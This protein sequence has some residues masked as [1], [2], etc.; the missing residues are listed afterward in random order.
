MHSVI[1]KFPSDTFYGGR[2]RDAGKIAKRKFDGDDL[3]KLDSIFQRVVFLDLVHS[4]EDQ[5]QEGKIFKNNAM[6]VKCTFY[7][8]RYFA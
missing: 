2:I 3:A 1:R 5:S 4:N 6:E 7:L 8:I